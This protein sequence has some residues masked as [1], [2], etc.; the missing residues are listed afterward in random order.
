MTVIRTSDVDGFALETSRSSEKPLSSRA[1]R[2]LMS[3]GCKMIE[4]DLQTVRMRGICISANR[5][6]MAST[7]C[8]RRVRTGPSGSF[9]Q[10]TEAFCQ[11]GQEAARSPCR[12]PE[13]AFTEIFGSTARIAAVDGLLV[14]IRRRISS[15]RGISS[16]PSKPNP[17]RNSR[18]G[19]D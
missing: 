4:R 13:M 6:A 7:S 10:V 15:L 19:I 1:L 9:L 5:R 18:A 17:F 11:A 14:L 8:S 16:A 3:F 2:S 12:R